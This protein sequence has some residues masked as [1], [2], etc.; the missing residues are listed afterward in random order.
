MK[1]TLIRVTLPIEQR[2]A[3]GRVPNAAEGV[4]LPVVVDPRNGSPYVPAS[5]LAGALRRHL[6]SD[7]AVKWLGPEPPGFEERTGDRPRERSPLAILGTIASVDGQ[8]P[9]TELRGATSI[10]PDRAAAKR[11][12]LRTEQWSHPATILVALAHEGDADPDLLDRL[13]SWTPVVGRG[14]STGMGSA[15]VEQVEHLTLDLAD[16]DQFTWWLNHRSDWLQNAESEAPPVTPSE[17]RSGTGTRGGHAWTISWEVAEPVHIGTEASSHPTAAGRPALPTLMLGGRPLIP[18]SSWKGVFRHRVHVILA[19]L[20]APRADAIL[21][22]LFGSE[23]AGRGLLGFEDTLVE[24]QGSVMGGRMLRRTH[25]AIDRF[26][27]GARDSA[28]FEVEAI[29]TRTPIG[30]TVR[31]ED[32]LPGC[33]RNLLGHVFRDLDEGLIGLGGMVTRGYGG[34]RLVA[35]FD[36]NA[37]TPVDLTQLAD[38]LDAPNPEESP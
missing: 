13:A 7:L 9:A 16:S 4:H 35:G 25:V 5:G 15:R 18:G 20:E 27:G 37:I 29:P 36:L 22:H 28:L 30:L 31:S 2:W 12:G 10:D 11:R 32:P 19:T 33:V 8:P 1:T 34:L 6:G 21:N 3:V 14:A 24:L 26:T 23:Q 17:P 38:L